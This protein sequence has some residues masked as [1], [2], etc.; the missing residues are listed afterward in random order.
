[1]EE[2]KIGPISRRDFLRL[3]AT[4][5]AAFFVASCAPQ[6]T[7]EA[8]AAE[9]GGAAA[10]GAIAEPA[11]E[12]VTVEFLAWGDPADI[13]AWEKLKTLYEQK[14]AGSVVNVTTVADPNANFYPKLQTM[15]AGGT[16]PHVSSFQ[17]WEWQTYADREVL[18]P[19]DDY[20]AAD[21]YFPKL[22][23]E[24]ILSVQQ[25]TKRNGKFYLIP[26]QLATMVMFY[27]KKHFDDAGL[28]Y[29]TDDWTYEQ[30]MEMAQ[31]LTDTS[32]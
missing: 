5:M 13:E 10:G 20:V 22:Y 6:A 15:L 16:P 29:P 30:F 3:S 12:S 7:P 28:P 8:P 2:K 27:A 18:A 32:G 1:M 31:T 24:D 25:S 11:A 14:N 19:I 17:G 9:A 23:P 4:G 26:M 21:S